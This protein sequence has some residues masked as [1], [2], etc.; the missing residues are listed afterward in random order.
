MTINGATFTPAAPTFTAQTPAGTENPSTEK[1][2]ERSGSEA[3]YVYVLT[4]DTTVDAQK[5]YYNKTASS[6]GYYVFEYIDG[7]SKEHY[8]VIKVVDM[9]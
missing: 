4:T 1:W 7:E 2:Y 5:T 3:P 9:Y 6:A 8:K